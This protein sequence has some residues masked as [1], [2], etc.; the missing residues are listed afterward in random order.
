MVNMKYKRRECRVCGSAE[1]KPIIVLPNYPMVAGPVTRTP[2]TVPTCNLE[3]GFCSSCGTC[4]SLNTDTDGLPYDDDYTSSNIAYGHVKSMDERTDRFVEFI[5][6]A[7]KPKRSRVLEIGCYEGTFMELL[8]KRYGF[9]M[10]GCEPCVAVAEEARGK[11][12]NVLPHEFRSTDYSELD[13]IVAR[14]ILEHITSPSQF[15]RDIAL[16]LKSDGAVILEVPAG[17]HYI[18]NGILG[19]IVPEH[20]CYFG[21]GSLERLLGDHFATVV[22]EED[23]AT[24]RALAHL[25][26]DD[27]GSE[28]DITDATLL[29]IGGQIRQ[30][31]YDAVREATE[32]ERVDIFGANTCTLELIAAGAIRIEQIDMVYD[33]DPRRWGRYL[34]NT[35]LVVSPR[36]TLRGWRRR[37]K[38]LVC[39]YTHRRPIA[40][41]ITKQKNIA[42]KLY[43][44][45][46]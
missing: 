41:Y 19:T 21:K 3:V 31:R 24:I 33:D 20:S 34:V 23:K 43:G 25:P 17:E 13:M 42:V 15:I 46:E 44:D 30:A 45:E 9:D 37:Q 1:L 38:V 36:G 4:V 14:N 22:I 28:G 35:N 7:Y 10:L 8:E 39:S 6:R 29:R 12:C 16:S 40:D 32:S 27:I 2:K 26:C 5:S 18:R 11:G